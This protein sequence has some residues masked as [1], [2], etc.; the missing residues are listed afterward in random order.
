MKTIVLL[1]LL[2]GV[3]QAAQAP[4]LDDLERAKVENLRLRVAL[5]EARR[6]ADVCR[7]V[8]G[9]LRA[10]AATRDLTQAQRE[11]TAFLE[12]RHPGYTWHPDTG[13]FTPTEAP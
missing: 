6:D 3:G 5:S 13:A 7:T 10:D 2:A 11:L 12:A 8:L 4:A 1:V 9:P